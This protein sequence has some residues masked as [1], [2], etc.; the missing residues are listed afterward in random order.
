M[1]NGFVTTTQ[2]CDN[3]KCPFFIAHSNNELQCEGLTEKSTIILRYR[4]NQGK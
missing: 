1:R 4:R 3:V 2:G